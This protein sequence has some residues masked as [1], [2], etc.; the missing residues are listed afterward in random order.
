MDVRHRYVHANCGIAKT[1]DHDQD[2]GA[3]TCHGLRLLEDG[4][5]RHCKLFIRLEWEGVAHHVGLHIE[6]QLALLDEMVRVHV[7]LI[8]ELHRHVQ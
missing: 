4:H 2:L 7:L 3:S 5:E 6:Q 8:F 1:L